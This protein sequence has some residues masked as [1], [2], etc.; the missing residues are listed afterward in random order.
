MYKIPDEYKVNK[1]I[2]IKTFI[3]SSLKPNEKQRLKESLLNAA[4]EYQIKGEKIPSVI[5]SELD[6]EVIIFIGIKV[7]SIKDASFVSD[8]IQNMGK[9]FY[10]LRIY[11]S[12]GNECYSFAHKRLNFEDRTQVVIENIV[13]SKIT[14]NTFEDEV[15]KLIGKYAEFDNIINKFNKFSMYIEMMVKTYIISNAYLWSKIETLL[16]SKLWYNTDE[17]IKVF[18][19]LKR[20]EELK[21]IQ[22]SSKSISDNSKIN[23][24]LRKIYSEFSEIITNS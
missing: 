12:L 10:I 1:N 14:S 22:K 9:P 13:V 11:D 21:K 7:K 24:E 5:T 3:A 2:A 18:L 16:S 15:N 8:T 4:I 6:C 19:K 23:S 20:V 17:V